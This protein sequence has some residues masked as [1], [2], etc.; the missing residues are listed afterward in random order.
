MMSYKFPSGELFP[1]DDLAPATVEAVCYAYQ[2]RRLNRV[3]VGLRE[4][5]ASLGKK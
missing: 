3:V 1:D 4:L 2:L 5:D